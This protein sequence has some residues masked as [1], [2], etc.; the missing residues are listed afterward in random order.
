[1]VRERDTERERERERESAWLDDVYIKKFRGGVRIS[2]TQNKFGRQ[3]SISAETFYVYLSS[4]KV[5]GDKK[6]MKEW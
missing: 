3:S 1:M 5:G 2:C 4:K 6:E